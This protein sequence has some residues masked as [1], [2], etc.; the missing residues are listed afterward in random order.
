MR[1]LAIDPGS[2]QSAYVVLDHSLRPQHFDKVDN[3]DLLRLF[4]IYDVDQM[5]IEMVGHYGSGMSAGK[6][7][8]DTCVWIGR[9]WQKAVGPGDVP[10]APVALALRKT[11]VTHH[12]GTAK[13]K[14]GNVV[15]A[16]VDR[17]APNERNHGKGVKNAPGW[18]YGF[19]SDLW[20]AYALAVYYMDT[21]TKAAA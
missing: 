8:F 5:V 16:L 18:F 15:Q 12:C 4:D 13:A 3:G 11:I 2:T 1:L 7:V 6:T 14:D 9:F 17:F 10:N 19:H 20:Q 21:H